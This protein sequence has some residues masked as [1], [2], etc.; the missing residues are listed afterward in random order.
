LTAPERMDRIS[1]TLAGARQRF[2]MNIGGIIAQAEEVT[3][4]GF[5]PRQTGP[6][7]VVLPLHY[8]VK[9]SRILF[10]HGARGKA[11]FRP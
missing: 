6:K 7:P 11:M 1:D 9:P 2:E 8:P 5:E 3:G 4:L 10:Q